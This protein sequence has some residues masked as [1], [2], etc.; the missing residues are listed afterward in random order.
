MAAMSKTETAGFSN[1]RETMAR[2]PASTMP[3]LNHHVV[4]A[5]VH[6]VIL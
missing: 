1:H 3:V 4:Y 5:I 6:F 2:G